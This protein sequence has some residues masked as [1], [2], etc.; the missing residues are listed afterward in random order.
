[1][2]HIADLGIYA[3]N[4]ALLVYVSVWIKRGLS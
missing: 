1:M 2:N 4:T 3:C